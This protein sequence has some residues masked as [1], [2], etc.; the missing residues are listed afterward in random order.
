[1]KLKE[2]KTSEIIQFGNT[3]HTDFRI[4]TTNVAV[5]MNLLSKGFYQNPIESIVREYM[6]NAWDSHVEADCQDQAIVVRFSKVEN[7]SYIEFIDY[8]VGLSPE[9][10]KEVFTVYFESSKRDTNEQ[11][12]SF[13]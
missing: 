7:T 2:V 9:R 1:M 12:G 4:S 8:G 13:G 3:N 10:V 11:T 6:S 5:I